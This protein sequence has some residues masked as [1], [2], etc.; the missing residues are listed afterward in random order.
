MIYNLGKHCIEFIIDYMISVT[1]SSADDDFV[2]DNNFWRM[3]EKTPRFFPPGVLGVTGGDVIFEDDDGPDAEVADDDVVSPRILRLLLED[4]AAASVCRGG[5]SSEDARFTVLAGLLLDLLFDEGATSELPST[6]RVRLGFRFVG[7]TAAAAAS[8]AASVVLSLLLARRGLVRVG[9][10]SSLVLVAVVL[11]FC[12]LLLSPVLLSVDLARLGL[13]RVGSGAGASSVCSEDLVR[14]SFDP[15]VA[16]SSDDFLDELLISSPSGRLSPLMT[17]F[18]FRLGVAGALAEDDDEDFLLL[19]TGGGG[20]GVGTNPC[21]MRNLCFLEVGCGDWVSSSIFRLEFC[22][23]IFT[24]AVGCGDCVI[25]SIFRLEPCLEIFPLAVGCGDCVSSSIFRLED[26]LEILGLEDFLGDRLSED[27][28]SDLD[29]FL[30]LL[31]F[32]LA[33]SLLVL[34]L[35]LDGDAEGEAVELVL[36]EEDEFFRGTFRGGGG[37][38][39]AELLF[40]LGLALRLLV[41]IEAALSPLS[42]SR[43]EGSRIEFPSRIMF[44]RSACFRIINRSS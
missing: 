37:G 27:S 11:D 35:P 40:L 31:F 33:A 13:V 24:L 44:I 20:G 43:L 25:S 28:F 15:V 10:A 19:S 18:F 16:F 23:T 41:G 39:G 22:L 3:E 34:L 6:D 36:R 17:I 7:S 38:G 8:A 14:R 4:A 30:S 21:L 9:A 32:A 1:R 29:F 12:L 26:C 2:L 5:W 42:S